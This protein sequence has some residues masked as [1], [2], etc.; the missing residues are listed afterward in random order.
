MANK[1]EEAI[2]SVLIADLLPSQK[3]WWSV[4]HSEIIIADSFMWLVYQLAAAHSGL[5][6][7]KLVL[8]TS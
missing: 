8:V 5:F 4:K 1:Q 6:E 2:N 3:K 7:T